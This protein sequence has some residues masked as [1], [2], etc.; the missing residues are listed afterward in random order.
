MLVFQMRADCVAH[1]FPVLIC[2]PACCQH[3]GI[4]ACT[5]RA[6]YAESLQALMRII[7]FHRLRLKPLEFCTLRRATSARWSLSSPTR[8]CRS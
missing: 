1:A 8:T 5:I 4:V 3:A 6:R 7:V 2:D